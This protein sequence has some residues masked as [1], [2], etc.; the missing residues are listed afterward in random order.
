VIPLYN[1][2]TDSILKLILRYYVIIQTE[3]FFCYNDTKQE[4]YMANIALQSCLSQ[5]HTQQLK[6]INSLYPEFAA[7]FL[8]IFPFKPLTVYPNQFA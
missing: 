1:A 4:N 6:L 3:T 2:Q 5:Q 8:V 7:Y